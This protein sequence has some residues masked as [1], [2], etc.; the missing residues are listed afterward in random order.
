MQSLPTCIRIWC[1]ACGGKQPLCSRHFDLLKTLPQPWW[2]SVRCKSLIYVYTSV[3][4]KARVSVCARTQMSAS[5]YNTIV[6]GHLQNTAALAA[7]PTHTRTQIPADQNTALHQI[8]W[9][10]CLLMIWCEDNRRLDRKRKREVRGE[11]GRGGE[12]IWEWQTTA[13]FFFFIIIIC[14]CKGAR[15]DNW[16]PKLKAQHAFLMSPHCCSFNI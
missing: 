14:R 1:T 2:H 10:A 11:D 9:K 3:C 16:P 5:L 7:P 8:H 6:H 12:A 13:G 15:W 4:R